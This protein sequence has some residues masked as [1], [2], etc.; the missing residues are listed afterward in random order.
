MR[1]VFVTTIS[2]TFNFLQGQIGYMRERGFDVHGVTSPGDF[3]EEIAKRENIPIHAIPMIRQ[4]T[5]VQDLLALGKF[6]RLFRRIKPTI[7]HAST[8]KGGVLGVIGGRLAGVP[9]VIYTL[10]GLTY[11]DAI[12]SRRRMLM[13]VEKLACRC[14][15]RVFATSNATR[16][17]VLEDGLCLA[18]KI[19]VIGHGT[20]NGIEAQERFNPENLPASTREEVRSRYN[21]PTNALVLGYVG[22]IVREKG[23]VELAKAWEGLRLKFLSLHLLLVGPEEE[24]DPVPAPILTLLKDDPRVRFSGRVK[25]M[26]SIYASMDIIPSPVTGKALPL[27]L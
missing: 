5:P 10:R 19:F 1:L 27:P 26:P 6:I 8:P 25:D 20:G 16:S 4:I 14:A 13:E 11:T 24:H 18:D 23:I 7:V 17:Q 3:L 2:L 21:I 15:Q 9:I 12:G 22:R